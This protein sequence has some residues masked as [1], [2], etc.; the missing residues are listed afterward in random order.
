MVRCAF[1]EAAGIVP[2]TSAIGTLERSDVMSLS[3][4]Q[5]KSPSNSL[6]A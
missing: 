2:E 5:P 4:Q 3:A 1:A 6:E